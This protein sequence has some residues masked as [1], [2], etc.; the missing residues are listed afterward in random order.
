[1]SKYLQL[2]SIHF[3]GWILPVFLLVHVLNGGNVKKLNTD[4][5]P[6]K[7][8]NPLEN[9]TIEELQL[10]GE[11][12]AKWM[13]D[14]PQ[15]SSMKNKTN[16]ALSESLSRLRTNPIDLNYQMQKTEFKSK[17]N[18]SWNK[19]NETPVFI[20]GSELRE[21][22]THSSGMSRQ[23]QAKEFIT[24]HKEI[25]KLENPHD[26]LELLR[27]TTDRYGKTH[28]KFQQ[29]HFG[30]PIWGKTVV[31]HFESDGEFYLLN[32]RYTPTP[33]N[34]DVTQVVFSKEQAIE[35]A[36][37]D[38]STFT[39]ITEF[40]DEMKSLLFYNGPIGKQ[41][42]W[43]DSKTET[44][45]LIW[46][47]QVRPNSKD[48]W[49]YFINSKT[50]E[51]LEKYNNTQSDGH[52][53]GTA[54]D[55][56]GE[57]QTV[58]TFHAFNTYYL[59]DGSRE[60]WQDWNFSDFPVGALLTLK[61]NPL[62]YITS[63]D[64]NVWEPVQVSAHSNV[65][66]V[67]QYFYDTFNR[68]AI[69]G[70][71]STIISIVNVLDDGEPMDNAYWNGAYMAYGDGNSLFTPLAGALD[72]AAHEMTHGIVERT[73][74]LEYKFESGA[75]NE[76]FADVFGAMVDSENWTIG[77]MI[78][79]DT[80]IYSTGALRDLSKPNQGGTTWTHKGWQ[81]AHWNEFLDEDDG[82]DITYDNGGVHYN[83]GIPNKACHLIAEEIG[84]EKTEQIY[85]RILEAE[86]L[87]TQA[88]FIDMRLAT[89][90]SAGELYGDDEVTAV[91]SAFDA[92]G[93]IDGAGSE[94]P[95]DLE[96]VQG[97]EWI[98]A[99]NDENG[100]HSL[101]LVDPETGEKSS[102]TNTQVST[103]ASNTI[104][105]D[106]SGVRIL[107]INDSNDMVSIS[108]T[109]EN[110]TNLTE[111]LG[112]PPGSLGGI[113]RSVSV[114]P[115]NNKIIANL[116]IGPTIQKLFCLWSFEPDTLLDTVY[117]DVSFIDLYSPTTGEGINSD[118]IQ[119]ADAMDWDP[120]SRYLIYDAFHSVPQDEGS[121]DYWA[122]NMLD[123]GTYLESDSNDVLI[124][125]FFPPQAEGIH[126]TNPAF[127]TTNP[128]YFVFDYLIELEG[129]IYDR[130]YAV[131]WFNS[132][133]QEIEYNG[134]S[135]GHPQYSPDDSK[136]IF[137]R[138]ANGVSTLRKI[139]LD[140][141]D[142]PNGESYEFISNVTS[143]YW[144]VIEGELSVQDHTLSPKEFSLN[145]NHPNPFNPVTHIDFVLFKDSH[146]KISIFDVSGR[147]IKILENRR[148]NFG[149]HSVSW[150]GTNQFGKIVSGGVYLCQ[151]E[152]DQFMETR[153]MVF[154][155]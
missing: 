2:I 37:N 48:N 52:T 151:L 44:P 23:T 69:D 124:Y 146:I 22:N 135:V 60:I 55:L 110:E 123:V 144:F 139:D 9:P 121:F 49:Y 127:S 84:R 17:Y 15:S 115:D 78:I 12:L 109:G 77:E 34:L 140:N 86:Y 75:L 95:V 45:Y 154:L 93:I 122:I 13:A 28:I 57:E 106:G 66:T 21:F 142:S 136:I 85:Y 88:T 76:S 97:E 73:V 118:V 128:N 20:N 147:E 70:A 43:I 117:V 116:K 148:F 90:Q 102:L 67:Y 131:D 114:S 143:P 83:S 4:R 145:Q 126:M 29:V 31:T 10:L 129:N 111:N 120:T 138:S 108:P 16:S 81:P 96:P 46:Y 74:N 40:S 35:I 105:T 103:E 5:Q 89:I 150:D 39:G 53:S 42:I 47:V 68:S 92:V 132:N 63:P 11:K 101:V 26:E 130:I 54:I 99:I 153:K 18:V 98:V 72:V 80:T 24:Y 8:D 1:M 91:A 100:D 27:E 19:N 56:N 149:N 71:G 112:N 113:W 137:Q 59:I 6:I 152:T 79:P 32:A 94:A 134:I 58:H 104:T 119:Y 41:Y 141:Q 50:G 30:I 125:S 155:K 65:G 87:N 14:V 82:W 3:S 107:F 61:D 25:F 64:V 51:I 62:N 36:L 33:S 133:T 7:T 38:V